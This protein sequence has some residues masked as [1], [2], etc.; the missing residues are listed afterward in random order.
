MSDPLSVAEAARSVL[1]VVDV[2]E[3]LH[4]LL[5]DADA[6]TSRIGQLMKAAETLAVPILVTEQYVQGLGPTIA[7]IREAAAARVV[8]KTTFSCLG[9][10]DFTEALRDLRR[11]QVV[12][13]GIEA[14]ICVL[15][16][17]LGLLAEGYDVFVVED[18]VSSR[19]PHTAGI[20]IARLRAAGA[21][22]AT[23]EGVVFEWMRRCDV[24]AF[25]ELLPIIREGR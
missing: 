10:S 17:G 7:P 19:M 25:K 12:L 8:E 11:D 14:H 24:P 2:L 13:A 15:Q 16:T 21:H 20:G 3:K 22:P 6:L 9:E 23:A 5:Q 1:V 4:P 18:A